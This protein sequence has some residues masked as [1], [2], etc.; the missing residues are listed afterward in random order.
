MFS[1]IPKI[2]SLADCGYPLSLSSFAAIQ[3]HTQAQRK[4]PTHFP[5]PFTLSILSSNLAPIPGYTHSLPH[6]CRGVC[7]AASHSARRHHRDHRTART[8]PAST[9]QGADFLSGRIQSVVLPTSH[10]AGHCRS[11]GAARTRAVHEDPL[12]AL[13]RAGGGSIGVAGPAEPVRICAHFSSPN[14][15]GSGLVFLDH[16]S[17][18][19]A[20]GK[21]Q[22]EYP[23]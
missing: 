11:H 1:Y 4:Y 8:S 15:I 17:S 13:T 2:K 9:R 5:P 20:S 16:C 14:A 6:D 21:H 18:L 23:G 19:Y 7:P 12:R 3:T 10:T 22:V